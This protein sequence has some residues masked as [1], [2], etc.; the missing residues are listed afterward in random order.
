MTEKEYRMKPYVRLKNGL[1]VSKHYMDTHLNKEY[2]PLDWHGERYQSTRYPDGTVVN[3]LGQKWGDGGGI[4]TRDELPY[5]QMAKHDFTY[6]LEAGDEVPDSQLYR[7]T[8]NS[9]CAHFGKE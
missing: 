9:L 7:D 5:D 1:K 6:G 3:H 2:Y 4:W 8:Y